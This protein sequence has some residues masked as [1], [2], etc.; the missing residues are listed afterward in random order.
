MNDILYKILYY[1][2]TNEEYKK[3]IPQIKDNNRSIS[4]FLVY[5]GS[6]T[7]FILFLVSLVFPELALFRK[8]YAIFTGIFVVLSLL[9]IKKELVPSIVLLYLSCMSYCALGYGLAF[10]YPT[11][12]SAIIHIIFILLPLLF[13][14]NSIRVFIYTLFMA[15]LYIVLGHFIQS[16]NIQFAEMYNTISLFFITNAIQWIINKGRLKGYLATVTSNELILSLNKAE[17]ELK[18][19]SSVDTLTGLK[20]RRS[21]YEEF[22][23]ISKNTSKELSGVLLMD[24][25]FFK[26]LNDKFG[27]TMGDKFLHEFGKLLLDFET[28]Y[29]LKS[30]RFGGEEFVIL[31]W[32]SSKEDILRICEEIRTSTSRINCGQN[33]PVTISIGVVYTHG[34]NTTSTDT[35]IDY[36]DSATYIAKK[37]GRNKI[38][39]WNDYN[40]HE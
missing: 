1:G 8:V 38:V 22:N 37:T 24:I 15:T 17:E 25:D 32:N 5:V 10:A 23:I 12:K 29:S 2:L 9:T 27:H 19:L 7:M 6:V 28:K 40:T 16:P 35:L 11:E 3:C 20:N 4:K 14:D 30:F 13:A 39:C 34:V 36:A 33:Y 21:L 26:A 18:V 31:F